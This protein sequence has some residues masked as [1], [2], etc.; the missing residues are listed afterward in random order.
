MLRNFAHSPLKGVLPVAI[1]NHDVSVLWVAESNFGHQSGIKVHSHDYYHLFMVRQ[2]PLEF[3]VG[4][5]TYMLNTDECV[6]AKPG[7]PHGLNEAEIPM[8]RCYEVKFTV[9]APR[10]EVLLSALPNHFPKD[11]F[12]AHMV[13][14]LV[15]ESTLQ[16]P[17][18]PA[19]VSG[20]MTSLIQYLYRHY[21]DKEQSETSVIDTVGYSKV[22]REIIQYLERNYD[23]DV[24]LQEIADAVGFNKNYICSVFKRDSGMTIGN[25]QTIIRIHKAAELISFSDMNLNQVAAATGFTNLSHF[26]RIFKKV[27]RIPPGQYRRMF[28]ANILTHGKVSDEIIQEMLEQNGFIVSVLGRKQLTIED[29]LLQ[30]CEDEGTQQTAGELIRTTASKKTEA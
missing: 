28:A 16:E 2:G 4:D 30:M 19:F 27:V 8:G 6:I 10:L 20:Y 23:R 1:L 18:T 14:E 5:K 26:N 22:S 12:A 15:R 7:V 11:S 13:Q 17:S 25:C 29:I 3:P 21:G 9:A 24:P